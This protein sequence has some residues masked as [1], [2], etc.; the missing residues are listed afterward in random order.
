MHSLAGGGTPTVA[1]VQIV[2]RKDAERRYVTWE[3]AP[4]RRVT[5]RYSCAAGRWE[6]PTDLGQL[7][8][9]GALAMRDGFWGSVAKGATFRSAAKKRTN[10]GRSV[11]LTNRTALDDA[12][13]TTHEHVDRWRTGQPTP[14]AAALDEMDRIWQALPRGQDLV[15][16][17]PSLRVLSHL[18]ADRPASR[19]MRTQNAGR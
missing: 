10:H 6:L 11:I 17:W 16:E 4:H 14:F 13:R 19:P 9:E 8:V 3:A 2:F 18:G 15:I 1:R 12:E 5:A 7:V